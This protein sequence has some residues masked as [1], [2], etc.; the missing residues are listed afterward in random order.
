L[1]FQSLRTQTVQDWDLVIN[2]E[3]ETAII[4]YA[5]MQNMINQL[6]MEGHGII[7]KKENWS[8]GTAQARNRC[9]A[10]DDWNNSLVLR[11]DD[12]IV[13]E[14]DYIEKLQEVLRAGFDI[15]SGVTPR[16]GM[17]MMRRSTEF[18]MPLINEVKLNEK[19]EFVQNGDDCGWAY[20]ESE[21][22]RTHHF[23]SCA[24]YKAEIHKDFTYED[25]L[26]KVGFREEEFFSF[27]ALMSNRKIGVHTGAVAWHNVIPSGGDRIPDYMECA[28]I[29]QELLEGF[30]KKNFSRLKEFV[31]VVEA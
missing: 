16:F 18:V 29:N 1:L 11:L 30:V 12:D 9:I 20:L 27:R 6:K 25:N 15:A 13:L 5:F 3:S 19:G 17:P 26:S 2:D 28:K 21:I 4:N 8:F 23:R 22:I 7:Y 10:L 31:T 14:P 24:L